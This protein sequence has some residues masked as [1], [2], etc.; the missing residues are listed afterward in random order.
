MLPWL[1]TIFVFIVNSKNPVDNLTLDEVVKIYKGD[2]T[3]WKEV[4]GDDEEENNSARKLV[5]DV[6]GKRESKIIEEAGY[7]PPH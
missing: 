1:Y 6:L 7:V 3:N 5:N 4:A 2:I